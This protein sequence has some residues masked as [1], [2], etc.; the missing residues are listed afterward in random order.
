VTTNAQGQVIP[1]S[2]AVLTKFDT[3]TGINRLF[4]SGNIAIYDTGGLINAPQIP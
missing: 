4:D 1:I 3:A 2:R